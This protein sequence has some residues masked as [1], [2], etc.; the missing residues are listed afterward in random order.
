MHKGMEIQLILKHLQCQICSDESHKCCW[1]CKVGLSQLG[2][3]STV[4]RSIGRRAIAYHHSHARTGPGNLILNRIIS[5]RYKTINRC[6][7][8][9]KSCEATALPPIPP[10][11]YD[12]F[13][14][15]ALLT[16]YRQLT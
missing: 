13:H 1:N 11:N 9:C 6:W 10:P 12:R 7:F 2:R 16:H 4:C 15:K 14:R 5:A 8:V 3:D